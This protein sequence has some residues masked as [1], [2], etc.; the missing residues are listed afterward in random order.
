ML[1]EKPMNQTT[2]YSPPRPWHRT[3]MAERQAPPYNRHVLY[4]VGFF[5]LL[6]LLA[7]FTL[8]LGN[9]ESYYWLYSQRLQWNYF[10][11]PP[12]VALWIR[13]FTVNGALDHLEGFIRLG[14]VVGAA[15][16][17]WAIY[18]TVSII[19]SPR[20]GWLAAVLYNLSFYASVIS[21]IIIW[22]DSP[23]MVFWTT[24]L[25]M[26]A[27]IC[28]NDKDWGSWLLFG[29]TSGL[30]IM[31]KVHGVFLWGGL[32]LYMLWQQ[33]AWLLRPQVYVSALIA[34]VIISPIV[35]WNVQ[36]D[37]ITYRFHS[38]RVEVDHAAFNGRSFIEEVVSQVLFNNPVLVFLAATALFTWRRQS[39]SSMPALSIYNL[40]G[41]PLITV[42]LGISLFRDTTLPHWSGPA[43]V[44]LVPLAA[45][46]LASMDARR[47]FP[48][49]LR[50]GMVAF[51]LFFIPWHGVVHFYPGT[52]GS[53]DPKILGKGDGSLDLYGWEEAGQAFAS[54]S[55]RE[56][57]AGIMPSN[58]PLVSYKWWGAHVEY[59]FGRPSGRTMIG[60][61]TTANLHHY[62]WKNKERVG[63]VNLSK[64]Y[65]IMPSDEYYDVRKMYSR[66]YGI[67]KPV[68]TITTYRSGRPAHRFYVYRLSEWKGGM[69]V[70]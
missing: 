33:R 29:L 24:S 48:K 20:A 14:S 42:L 17:T 41:L 18:K 61:G 22:P 58:A 3:A 16:S 60:L 70:M 47:L 44:T 6:R 28:R 9:D 46:Q 69:P 1:E 4:L 67:I 45:V 52:Y 63:V 30:C 38:E 40:V 57:A 11:H 34:L 7:A 51:F 27:R 36:H 12:V 23:Q 56:Q 8:E 19:H 50:W 64:A 43:Y 53:Q 5:S 21:G 35:V 39:F 59:Y 13:L 32:V 68:S 25:W 2:D 54:L 49:L 31:S 62:L 15:L 37:F 66:Y 65:C 55:R 26:L 10:D